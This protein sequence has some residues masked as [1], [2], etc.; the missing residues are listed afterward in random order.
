MDIYGIKNCDSC[1]KA[2]NWLEASGRDFRWHDLREDGVDEALLGRWLDAV[3]PD[4]LVNRRSTTWRNLEEAE[5]KRAQA[6][7]SA[8]TLLLQHPTLIKRPI[9]DVHGRIMVGFNETVKQAL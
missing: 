8:L 7:E 9:F 5:R 3:G 1:R 2:R 6:R 4:K